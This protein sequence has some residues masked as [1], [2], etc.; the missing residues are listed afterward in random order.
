M[1][2]RAGITERS[3]ILE[4]YEGLSY[5]TVAEK[6]KNL[7]KAAVR[8]LVDELS[9]NSDS[10]NQLNMLNQF[11]VAKHPIFL[12]KGEKLRS[13]QFFKIILDLSEAN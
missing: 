5:S 3:E 8:N 13:S 10:I 6:V 9:T 4:K 11:S 2:T 1:I 7:S 12:T